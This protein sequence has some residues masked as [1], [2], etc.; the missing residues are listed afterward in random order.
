MMKKYS[1]LTALAALILIGGLAVFYGTSRA[2]EKAFPSPTAVSP[3][4]SSLNEKLPGLPPPP[5]E[6]EGTPPTR[7][8]TQATS[9]KET[10]VSY[11]DSGFLPRT[12]TIKRGD[13]V[14]FKNESA[15]S[16][17]VASDPHPVHTNYVA[18][19]A[20]RGYRP[21]ETYSFT[22]TRSGTWGYHN[23]LRAG[24]TGTVVVV[25]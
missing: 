18:F 20:L 24:D 22:F 10:I 25:P 2:P 14:T 19:D 23:H 12:I 4:H 3:P 15:H 5:A 13:T 17:W 9:L 16:M 1:Y 21:G 8:A 6:N 11:T 7:D